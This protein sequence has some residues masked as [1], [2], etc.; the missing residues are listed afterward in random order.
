MPDRTR[1]KLVS[2]LG[3]VLEQHLEEL[4]ELESLNNGRPTRETRAQ[5]KKIPDLFRYNAGLALSRRDATIPVEGNYLTYTIREPVGIVANVTPFNHPGVTPPFVKN[6]T[7]SGKA[8]RKRLVPK[9]SQFS[10]SEASVTSPMII[11]GQVDVFPLQRGEVR[12]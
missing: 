3:D 5:L 2:S 12:K 4:F 9:W 1:A 11:S 10:I 8:G 6:C 7:L